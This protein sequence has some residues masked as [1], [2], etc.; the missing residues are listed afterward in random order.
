MPYSRISLKTLLTATLLVLLGLTR[1]LGS[2][3]INVGDGWHTMLWS[4]TSGAFDFMGPYTFTSSTQVVVTIAD[5]GYDF[6]QYNVYDLDFGG[7]LGSTSVPGRRGVFIDNPDSAL[8]SA[9]WSHGQFPL[10]G[11]SHAIS[12]MLAATGPGDYAGLAMAFLRVDVVGSQPG[13]LFAPVPVQLGV[14]SNF[15]V[16]VNP[17]SIAVADFNRD[18]NL[19]VVTANDSTGDLSILLGD[20]KGGFTLKTNYSIGT[21]PQGVA[22]GDFD[23]DGIP[24]IVATRV[25]GNAFILLR[26]LG[27]GNFA[28]ATYQNFNASDAGG[29]VLVGD[30]NNDKKLDIVAAVRPVGFTASLGAGNGS[31]SNAVPKGVY[32]DSDIAMGD[33][34]SDGKL[35]MVVPYSSG[36]YL[37]ILLGNGDG[38]FGPATN[39]AV[40]AN[41]STSVS[42]VVAV[43]DLNGDGKLDL[44]AAGQ[45]GTNCI[46]VFLGNGDG[47]FTVKTNYGYGFGASTIALGDLNGDK[48]PDL[49]VGAGANVYVMLGNGDGTFGPRVN[50]PVANGVEA[51]AIADFNNDGLPDIVSANEY[52]TISVLLNQTFPQL[53][54]S[55]ATNQIVLSW[56]ASAFGFQVETSTSCAAANSWSAVGST[57][58]VT[59]AQNILTNSMDVSPRFYRL[60]K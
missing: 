52:G 39:Y 51:L 35:D 57:P 29:A 1:C 47:S 44:V 9:Q 8:A 12:G 28:P 41:L 26:G 43:A 54:I 10:S 46:T 3:A 50:F 18:G 27:D 40:P 19:D 21:V 59:G 33:F 11:G 15:N 55:A 17:V 60:R 42:G 7:Y 20:G 37:T 22:V 14:A 45:S 4:E 32:C 23:G 53:Q 38:T 16:G 2:T 5:Y 24:D 30:F 25:Y 58:T 56:P 34:N 13:A 49:I 36:K 6:E 48:I 31:F